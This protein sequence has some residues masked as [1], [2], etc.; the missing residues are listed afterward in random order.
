MS[1]NKDYTKQLNEITTLENAQAYQ[2]AAQREILFLN[3][4]KDCLTAQTFFI[5]ANYELQII[6]AIKLAKK[7]E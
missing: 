5:H 4:P 3:Q 7:A 6:D 1:F 2:L